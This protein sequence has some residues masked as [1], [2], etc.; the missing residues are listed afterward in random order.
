MRQVLEDLINSD[1]TAV[2]IDKFITAI[3]KKV[4]GVTDPLKF[5][6]MSTTMK[7]NAN[8]AAVGANSNAMTGTGLFKFDVNDFAVQMPPRQ[9]CTGKKPVSKKQIEAYKASLLDKGGM[10]KNKATAVP[11]P[12]SVG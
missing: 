12:S 5:A 3:H 10:N 1:M 4:A 8:L 2:G 9:F 11:A 7:T 6:S